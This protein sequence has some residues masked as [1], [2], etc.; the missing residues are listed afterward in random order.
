[1]SAR[2]AMVLISTCSCLSGCS[3][4]PLKMEASPVRIT[5]VHFSPSLEQGKA[6]FIEIT[7][8][9]DATV[10]LSNWYVTG[11][12]RVPIP[13]G[14]TLAPGKAI[15]LCKD[16]KAVEDLAGGSLPV[17]ATFVGKLKAKGET[18]RIED[19]AGRIADEVSYDPVDP[20]V[21]EATGT[22]L[23]IHRTSSTDPTQPS[24]KA[25]KPTPG[26]PDKPARASAEKAPAEKAPVRSKSSAPKKKPAPPPEPASDGG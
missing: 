22:G 15:I 2:W 17:V 14:T 4:T 26:V 9:S 8:T 19:E 3:S 7:N 18:V 12:G 24:W 10:D 20:G 11:A 5:E 13:P 6:E 21:P 1:M 16:Q 23:S 25:A